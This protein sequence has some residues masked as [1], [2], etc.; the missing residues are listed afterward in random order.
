M[1]LMGL[2][3]GTQRVGVALSDPLG[4]TAQAHSVMPRASFK[5]E[6]T[7]LHQI[8]REYGV[9]R[10]IFGIPLGLQG[11]KG[12]KAEEVE[13]YARRLAQRLNLPYA[14]VDERLSTVSAQNLLLDADVS[15]ARR[16][17]VVDKMAAAYILQAYMD[18]ERAKKTGEEVPEP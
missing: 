7:Y 12:K 14:M 17:Q 2:D 3:V 6:A 11:E 15:R 5:T 10:L 18:R 4:W 1:R 13:A 8:C 9:E 16:R